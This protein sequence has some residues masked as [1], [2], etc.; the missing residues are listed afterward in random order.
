MKKKAGLNFDPNT[1]KEAILKLLGSKDNDEANEPDGPF[2][3]SDMNHVPDN[4][5]HKHFDARRRWRHCKTIGDVR[6]QGHCGS[7]WVSFVNNALIVKCKI[8]K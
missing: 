1:P 4:R 7:C 5:I 6:D 2:K 3:T 8:S